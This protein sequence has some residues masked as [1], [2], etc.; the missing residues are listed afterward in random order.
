[1]TKPADTTDD[2]GHWQAAMALV[3]RLLD[4]PE[5]RRLQALS[6]AEAPEEVR[7]LASRL[8]V[9]AQR[10]SIL[11]APLPAPPLPEHLGGHLAGRRLGRWL[12]VELLGEGGMAVVYR[13]RSLQAPVGQPAA[14]KLLSMAAA[15]AAGRARFEREIDI[16]VRLRHPGIAPVL[17]AG[18]ADD[19]T[20]WFA[21]SLVEG[22]D[23]A[24]WCREQGLG[25]P[26]RVELLLQV[27]DAVAHAHR[28]LVIHRDIKPSNVMVDAEGR[29]ILLDFGISR[30]LAEGAAEITSTGLYAFTPRYAAPEQLDGGAITTATDVYSLGSLLHLLLLGSAPQ[31]PPSAPHAECIDPAT[32]ARRESDRALRKALAGDL[33][34]IL[35]KSLARDAGLR[36]QGAAELAT[37]LR[38]W[39]DG[40]PVT[41]HRDSRFYRL[42]RLAARHRLASGL[43]IALTISLVT[44][45]AAFAWQAEHA[46]REAEAALQAKAEADASR[47][48]TARALERANVL[49][50][51]IIDLFSATQPDRPLNELPTTEELLEIGAARARDPASGPPEVRAQ[52]LT[53]ISRI[54]G[55]R[56]RR[57]I[58][59][60]LVDEAIGLARSDADADGEVLARALMV[61]ADYARGKSGNTLAAALLDEAERAVE[62]AG[63]P[64]P[65][66]LEV[67]L[68][69]A[70]LLSNT[71]RIH[72]AIEAT[73][74]LLA[75]AGQRTDLPDGFLDLLLSDQAANY[76]DAQLHASAYEHF[77][78]LLAL[79]RQQKDGNL[80]RYTVS[81][82]SSALNLL[83]LGDFAEAG[84]RLDEAQRHYDS[85][86]DAPNSYRAAARLIRAMLL[87]RQRRFDEALA[88]VEA[89]NREWALSTGS[90]P[91]E[92]PFLAYSR[93][94]VM[95]AAGR[96]EQTEA[97]A[98]RALA[99]FTPM[100]ADHRNKMIKIESVLAQAACR[101]G[102]VET[103]S[104]LIASAR[105]R[106]D[107]PAA[108]DVILL[109]GLEEAQANCLA[110][111]G[112]L[113]GALAALD[114]AGRFDA[115]YAPGNAQDLARRAALR[116]QLLE[117][118]AD[119][120]GATAWTARAQALLEGLELPHGRPWP[121]SSP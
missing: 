93:M 40:H 116:A 49:N 35:R 43:V 2:P 27:C 111:A 90:D 77:E 106:A 52:M 95:E 85:L 28:H 19:G 101:R 94:E 37:D 73:G 51:F 26:Q 87:T 113:D 9:A 56:A 14:L 44:G 7:R 114:A 105:A 92:F 23:I 99:L 83:H 29:A 67:R 120:A 75:E 63:P 57:E 11:D 58:G 96:A 10:D 16:L 119:P 39:R 15:T 97:E 71:G 13:A 36:Y 41:A 72:E 115:R 68:E 69:K 47:L 38:A 98:A 74:A 110:A 107:V 89:G 88:E 117:A 30:I 53:V 17:D 8:L 3:G 33:G 102:E 18:V 62:G 121:P 45:I 109:S 1:M 54:H 91:A 22:I 100:A 25:V 104:A 20:P 79:R 6:D 103:G 76:L 5:A 61:R 70:L 42:G 21:M 112:R 108:R 48:N 78:E 86:F 118:A 32:I 55:R 82:A 80:L 34:A 81:L 59:I 46:T 66:L 24:A 31:F 64:S 84:R 4:L 65:T 50:R 60:A 12:L